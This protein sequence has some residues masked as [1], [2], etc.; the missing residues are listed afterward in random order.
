MLVDDFHLDPGFDD[1][2]GANLFGDGLAFAGVR[3]W[4]HAGA[5]DEGPAAGKKGVLEETAI[6]H[7][8]APTP[9]PDCLGKRD[10][11]V[12]PEGANEEAFDDLPGG[13]GRERGF[14][15]WQ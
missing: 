7:S 8:R 2:G 14:A 4:D 1:F 10:E 6:N 11:F 5:E 12:K 9:G 13:K 15:G 3:R